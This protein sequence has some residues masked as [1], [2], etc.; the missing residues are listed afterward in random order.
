MVKIVTVSHENDVI[1]TFMLFTQLAGATIKYIDSK[2]YRDLRIS[3]IK[4]MALKV[5]VINGG[6]MKHSELALWTNTKKHNITALVDRM[7]EDQLVT[8]VRGV[9]DKRVNNIVLT[10]RGREI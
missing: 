9:T 8:T 7:K 4:Y 6:I 2:F 1:R 10:D 3:L 5:L